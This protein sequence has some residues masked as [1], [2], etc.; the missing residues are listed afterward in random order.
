MKSNIRVLLKMKLVRFFLVSG[1]NTAFGYGLFALLTYLGLNYIL[2][3]LF[4]T[5]IGILFNFKTIGVL[6]F[7]T[8]NNG[9]IFKFFGV[10]GINYV[11]NVGGL[12]LLK[13]SGIGAYAGQ[14]I[15]VV[16]LGV[17]GFLLNKTFVFKVKENA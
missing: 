6:V 5:I 16:P 8:H 7:R 10:Y 4:A 11:V 9:L 1:L 17:M 3:L 2:A 14:A 15:L 13:W 12:S